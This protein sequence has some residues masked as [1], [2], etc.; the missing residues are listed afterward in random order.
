MAEQA[1]VRFGITGVYTDLRQM[2][3]DVRPDVVHVTTPPRSHLPIV[4]TVAEH[5]A[6]AYVEKPF[7]AT[8]AEAEE[9]VNLMTRAGLLACVGHCN[10]FDSA[11]LRLKQVYDD[12]SLGE[13][14]HIDTVMGYNLAGPFGA[15]MMGDPAHWVHDLPGGITHNNISHPLSLLLPFLPD[16]TP[17]VSAFG[18]RCRQQRFGD[19]RDRFFD[20]VRVTLAGNRTTAT[21]QFSSRVRP[22]QMFVAVHGTDAYAIASLDSRTLRIVR[23][24][25]WPGP[26]ARVQWSYRDRHQAA[27]G[28]RQNLARVVKARLHYFEGMHELIRRFYYAIQGKAEMPIPMI[29]ALRATRIMDEIF[30]Q[31]HARTESA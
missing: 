23:G 27:A 24:A 16:D 26:F 14:V 18:L 21:I 4:R 15:V 11:F 17:F 30:A 19:R 29:E 5:G 20:E 1:A 22:P 31:C 7:T 10:A 13:A 2:L 25:T 28:F 6:H 3:I 8:V 12:G 9:L